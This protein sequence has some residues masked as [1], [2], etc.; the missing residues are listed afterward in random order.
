MDNEALTIISTGE[1]FTLFPSNNNNIKRKHTWYVIS[2]RHGSLF[3]FEYQQRTIYCRWSAAECIFVL[4]QLIKYN[5]L[6]P[7]LL[8]ILTSIQTSYQSSMNNSFL[9]LINIRTLIKYFSKMINLEWERL[10]TLLQPC[11][12]WISA[13]YTRADFSSWLM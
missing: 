2:W 11:C 5:V 4:L 13:H 3:L 6:V 9:E 7:P 1:R 12:M 10:Y 8:N